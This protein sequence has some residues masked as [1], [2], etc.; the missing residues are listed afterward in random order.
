MDRYDSFIREN[1]APKNVKQI[2]VYNN[3]GDR[4]GEIPLG[5]LKFPNVGQKLYSFGA[6]SDIH[7]Q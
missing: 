4:V 6:V 2:G 7:L 5:S 3:K 1:V